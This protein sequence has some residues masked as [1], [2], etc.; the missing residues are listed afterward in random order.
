MVGMQVVVVQCDEGGNVDVSDLK[1]KAE[2]HAKNLAALMITYPSTH[3]IFE[4][5]IKEICG[6]I[7][8]NG[9]QVYI[10]GANMNAMVGLCQPGKFGGDVSHLNLHKTF[11]IPHG[12]GGPG[13]GP[14]GVKSHLIPFLPGHHVLE[15]QQSAVCAAPWGSASILPISWT[16]IKLMG[17]EGLKQASQ[18]AILNAN[19]IA[20]RLSAHFPILYAGEG[21]IVA[22]ECI[23]DLRPLKD[24]TGVT[25]EDVAKRLM[26]FG[27]HA[28][29][30]SFPVP[31][32]LMI[33][34]TESEDRIELDRFCDAMIAIRAEIADVA[35]GKYT[36]ETSPLRHAPHTSMALAGEWPHPYSREVAAFPVASL[37]NGNK[38]WPPVGR[39][40]NVYGDRNVICSCPPLSDYE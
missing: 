17:Q 9:G 5:A 33:E 29:T 12:G 26:D 24:E 16:Y 30:M 31:G 11:C 4:A 32:T 25:V 7:H 2:L 3:G 35:S 40:D 6:I 14:I 38:Y 39:V 34:P 23:V 8:D 1:A 37:K 27:F 13:V 21:G 36:A 18:V 20:K 15:N 22:H 19:Y 10:D 28:P